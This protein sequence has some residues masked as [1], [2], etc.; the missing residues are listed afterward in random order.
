MK[1]KSLLVVFQL[2]LLGTTPMVAQAPAVAHNTWT[3]G[4]PMPKARVGPAVAVLEGQI[5]AVGGSN[6]TGKFYS[7]TYIYDPASNV[8]TTGVSFPTKVAGA[9]GAVVKNI[10]Y[11][12]G[13]TVDGVT[14]SNAVWA[15]SPKTQTWSEK[16][17]MP[18]ARHDAGVAVVD[19]IIYVVGGNGN[20]GNLRL[21]SV[22]SYNPATDSWTEEAPLLVGKSEPSVGTFGNK[23]IGFTIV[24]ADGY[25]ADSDTGDNEAYDVATNTWT[26]LTPDP[27]A[28]NGACSGAIGSRMYIAGGSDGYYP[29]SSV[30]EWFNLSKNEWSSMAPIPQPTLFSGSAVYKGQLYCIGGMY[31]SGVS[32]KYVQIYQP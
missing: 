24:A 23:T 16:T 11:V 12:M 27:T 9:T 22:E 10:L 31:T 29:A 6:T 19:N 5:Y 21:T 17:A 4:A 28:R 8:W 20:D 3:S 18:T 2:L 1:T 32:L 25:T 15:Y 14:Y 26:S 7:N 30:S 13:G